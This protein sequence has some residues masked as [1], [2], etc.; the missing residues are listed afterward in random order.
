MGVLRLKPTSYTTTLY[1][2]SISNATIFTSNREPEDI[3]SSS[4]DYATFTSE[5][6]TY[7]GPKIKLHFSAISVSNITK[8]TL[9]YRG[10]QDSGSSGT[11]ASNGSISLETSTRKTICLVSP[12][13]R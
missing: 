9:K 2:G 12:I 7:N 3:A 5:S 6:S 4:S 11:Y 1:S 8:I 10:H 13:T